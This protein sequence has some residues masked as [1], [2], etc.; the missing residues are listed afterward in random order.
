MVPILTRTSLFLFLSKVDYKRSGWDDQIMEPS[1]VK[2]EYKE[3]PYEQTAMNDVGKNAFHKVEQ[4][5]IDIL[6]T[7]F[8]LKETVD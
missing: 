4:G 3:V 5:A 6:K 1:S 8:S 7:R 2:W